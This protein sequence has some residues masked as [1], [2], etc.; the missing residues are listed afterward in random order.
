[1]PSSIDLSEVIQT[2]VDD[3][4]VDSTLDNNVVEEV[5]QDTAQVDTP[6][7]EPTTDSTETA[8]ETST[9]DQGQAD[10]Q[11]TSQVIA[12]GPDGPQFAIDKKLGIPSHTNGRENRIPYSRVKKIVEGA[13]KRALE[14]LQKQLAELTPKLQE[15]EQR[16]AQVTEFEQVM[17]NDPGKFLDMLSSLPAYSQ[18]F[19]LLEQFVT[20]QGQPQSQAP[21]AEVQ[22]AQILEN[23]PMPE[24]D[25]EDGSGYTMEGLKKLLEWN[26]R[27]VESRVTRQVEDRY[28]PIK[29][30]FDAEQTISQLTPYVQ[31]QM[32]EAYK[33]PKFAENE[34]EIVK[35]L[36]QYPSATLEQAYQHVVVPKLLADEQKLRADIRQQVL[37]ELKKAPPV[38]TG[39]PAGN[40]KPRP[41]SASSGPRKLEDVITEQLKEKGLF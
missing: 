14:P 18:F 10:G 29:D 2:A 31:R 22:T 16:L 6:A 34:A 41:A 11:D 33:W 15:Y 36:Q 5:S 24:P 38:S 8:P 30:R 12:G 20:T 25:N 21:T 26:S 3:T 4:H 19:Q 7:A 1:M 35:V 13:E 23:D 39:I 37:G 32:E 27:V 17:V 9:E 28:K 40:T